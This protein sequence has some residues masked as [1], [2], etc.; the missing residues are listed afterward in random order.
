MGEDWTEAQQ[1]LMSRSPGPVIVTM[2][3]VLSSEGAGLPQDSE[4]RLWTHREWV[5]RPQQATALGEMG[6]DAVLFT[7][8]KFTATSTYPAVTRLSVVLH[9]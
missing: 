5:R 1:L 2:V 3:D 6:S 7:E 4:E 9:L 8:W